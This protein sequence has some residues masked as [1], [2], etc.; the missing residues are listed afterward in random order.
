MPEIRNLFSGEF[1]YHLV[2]E[3]MREGSPEWAEE[4]LPFRNIFWRKFSR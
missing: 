3:I 4:E 2:G 1:N